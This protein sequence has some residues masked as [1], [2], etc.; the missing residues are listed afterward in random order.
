MPKAYASPNVGIL[1]EH[2]DNNN[3]I[4]ISI[5][6]NKIAHAQATSTSLARQ[7][8]NWHNLVC[9]RAEY[10]NIFSECQIFRPA[11]RNLCFCSG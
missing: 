10:T 9:R 11:Q 2:V 6:I 1:R 8:I 4:W 5:I 3:P 7:M